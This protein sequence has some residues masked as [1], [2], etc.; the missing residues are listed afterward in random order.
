LFTEHSFPE[1]RY[2][3]QPGE[4]CV[5]LSAEAEDALKKQINLHDTQNNFSRKVW[6]S[7]FFVTCSHQIE[8][9][10]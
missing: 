9:N 1:Q 8:D 5:G 6:N 4:V 10:D 3:G 2:N 7:G